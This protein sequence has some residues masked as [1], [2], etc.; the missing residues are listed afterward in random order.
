M[1]R[2]KQGKRVVKQHGVDTHMVNGVTVVDRE[3]RL[4]LKSTGKPVTILMAIKLIPISG[5]YEYEDRDEYDLPRQ[6]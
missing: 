6:G 5:M 1:G 2:G 4:P 3:N